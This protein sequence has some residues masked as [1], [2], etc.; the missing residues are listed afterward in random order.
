[1]LENTELI[2]T[3]IDLESLLRQ[4]EE[5]KQEKDDLELMLET[6]TEHATRVEDELQEQNEKVLLQWTTDNE[7]NTNKFIV[8]RSADGRNYKAIGDVIKN[9]NEVI[10]FGPTDAKV[11]L[12]NFLKQDHHFDNIKI[13]VKN[14]DKMTEHQEFAFVKAHFKI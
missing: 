6:T 12:V 2:K 10:V 9:F 5:L 14:S 7:I 13:E 8:E 3:E 1:M 4:L 11:E